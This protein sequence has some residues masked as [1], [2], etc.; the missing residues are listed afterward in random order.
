MPSTPTHPP[1]APRT[2]EVAGKGRQSAEKRR[3]TSS[4]RSSGRPSASAGTTATPEVGSTTVPP[5]RVPTTYRASGGSTG[6]GWDCRVGSPRLAGRDQVQVVAGWFG[7]RVLQAAWRYSLMSPP[8]VVC[9]RIGWPGP[10]AVTSSR[11]LG[12]R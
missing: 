7:R 11:S 4:G 3:I 6:C 9:H 1:I 5:L 2:A 8:Q 12:E 10:I